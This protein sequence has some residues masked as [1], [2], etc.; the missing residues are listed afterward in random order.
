M[1]S[2]RGAAP[3]VAAAVADDPATA[4]ELALERAQSIEQFDNVCQLV[5]CDRRL[6]LGSAAHSILLLATRITQRFSEQDLNITDALAYIAIN[7][8]TRDS[9]LH[10]PPGTIHKS[11][12][13]A[14]A[15]RALIDSLLSTLSPPE[16]TE[17]S[18]GATPADFNLRDLLTARTLSRRPDLALI[19]KTFYDKLRRRIVAARARPGP[20]PVRAPATAPPPSTSSRPA[21][22]AVAADP[23]STRASSRAAAA[24]YP[25]PTTHTPPSAPF[26]APFTAHFTAPSPGHAPVPHAPRPFLRLRAHG[27]EPIELYSS[28]ILPWGLQVANA[29]VGKVQLACMAAVLE[30]HEPPP[31]P[32]E[33]ALPLDSCDVLSAVS[34]PELS[35]AQLSQ[36]T[37]LLATWPLGRDFTLVVTSG[38]LPNPRLL[39]E[40]TCPRTP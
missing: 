5:R 34:I 21:V 11:R 4:L 18:F 37:A 23:R 17:L 28:P 39:H 10:N 35:Y 3:R 13:T 30:E 24:P 36:L 32:D 14:T 15:R 16:D 2:G 7:P 12:A 1:S 25:R 27:V 20:P 8:T 40:V 19:L 22:A 31:P 33:S 29:A 6:A 26:T 9:F 38:R